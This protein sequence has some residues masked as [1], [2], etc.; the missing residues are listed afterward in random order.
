MHI[1]SLRQSQGI[2]WLKAKVPMAGGGIILLILGL[3]ASMALGLESNERTP[4]SSEAYQFLG[5]ATPTPA[6]SVFIPRVIV[7]PVGQPIS[8]PQDIKGVVYSKEGLPLAGLAVRVSSP[9]WEAFDSTRGD[10]SFQFT[11]NKGEYSL[12][13]VNR[14]SQPAFIVVD[15]NNRIKVEF[16]ET[17]PGVTPTPNPTSKPSPT[18]TS[19]PTLEPSTPVSTPTITPTTTPEP[20]EIETPTPAKTRATATA[21]PKT[22]PIANTRGRLST[23][24]LLPQISMNSWARPLLIGAGTMTMAFVIGLVV[25]ILRRR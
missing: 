15:G 11:L 8:M 23:G 18:S 12:I 6:Y 3:W 16:W 25:T 20:W 7:E 2:G 22:T 9:G 19:L 10:G 13:L 5:Q 4:G 14:T 21:T 24:S 1:K 17:L